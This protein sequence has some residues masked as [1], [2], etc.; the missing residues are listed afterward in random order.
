MNPPRFRTGSAIAGLAILSFSCDLALGAEPAKLQST[1]KGHTDQVRSVAFSPDGALLASGGWDKTVRVWDVA[2]G[3]QIRTIDP[4]SSSEK[5]F[6]ECVAFS[7]DDLIIRGSRNHQLLASE[8]AP[9]K[10]AI[11][12]QHF[13]Q[14]LAPT[15][16]VNS[17]AISPTGKRIAAGGDGPEILLANVFGGRYITLLGRDR[18]VLSVVF[19]PNGDRLASAGYEGIQLWDVHSA[20]SIG[21]FD[22]KTEPIHAVAFSPDGELLASAGR[23]KTVRL[24]RVS[25]GENIA[26]LKGHSAAVFCVV[27]FPDGTSIASSSADNTIKLWDLSANKSTATLTGH[28][29]PVFSIA[30]TSDGKTLASGS[31]DQT[32]KLWEL[33]DRPPVADPGGP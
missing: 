25:T 15:Q 14:M 16:T 22:K 6:V 1:L 7:S 2:T 9:S 17:V 8:V 28:E 29:G 20:T 23:D 4:P 26:T 19:S 3:K 11:F 5:E 13:V 21:N 10:K 30:L 24:W 33:S 27:F 12:K 18:E 32:V 31:A